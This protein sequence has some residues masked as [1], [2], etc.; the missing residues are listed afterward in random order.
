M[1]SVL[2]DPWIPFI[3][4]DVLFAETLAIVSALTIALLVYLS[5]QALQYLNGSIVVQIRNETNVFCNVLFGPMEKSFNELGKKLLAPNQSAIF[6]FYLWN[7]FKSHKNVVVITKVDSLE[8]IYFQVGQVK[9]FG[10]FKICYVKETGMEVDNS[11]ESN[12][13]MQKLPW[14]QGDVSF[15]QVTPFTFLASAKLM[16]DF[17]YFIAKVFVILSTF[18]I[19]I[20]ALKYNYT[21]VAKV[22][23]GLVMGFVFCMCHNW[24]STVIFIW[25]YPTV[26]WLQESWPPETKDTVLQIYVTLTF[27]FCWIAIEKTSNLYEKIKKRCCCCKKREKSKRDSVAF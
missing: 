20:A 12:T 14:S 19:P 22:L 10:D 7:M 21:I 27:C 5:R 23:F 2:K 4:K 3:P 11:E 6:K 26:L 9:G 13:T 25:L 16:I 18:L 1:N 24:T 17:I 8:M 15:T